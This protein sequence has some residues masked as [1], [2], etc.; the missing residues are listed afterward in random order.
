MVKQRLERSQELRI[1]FLEKD[2]RILGEPKLG[3]SQLFAM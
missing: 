1:N 3:M 2:C